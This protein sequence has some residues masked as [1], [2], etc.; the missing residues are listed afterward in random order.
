[1]TP[2]RLEEA[3]TE[4]R[5]SIQKQVAEGFRSEEEIASNISEMIADEYK[6][7]LTTKDSLFHAKRI[8]R[9][10]FKNHAKLQA[11]WP[12]ETDCDRLDRAFAALENLGIIARQDFTCCTNCGSAEIRDEIEDARAAGRTVRG[13]TFYHMQDTERAAEGLGLY[14]A[15][16]STERSTDAALG[17]ASKIVAMLEEYG[18]E[19]TWDGTL[20][21]RIYVSIDW[22]RRRSL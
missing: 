16:G 10:A 11:S 8:T 15:Y 21:T 22:K 19:T 18:F 20:Q 3:L 1:V 9:E 12:S 6:D 5:S 2:D 7:I 17:V 13:Y 4:M 14:L